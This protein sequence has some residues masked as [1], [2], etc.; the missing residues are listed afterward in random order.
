MEKL[1]RIASILCDLFR[2]LSWGDLVHDARDQ[3]TRDERKFDAVQYRRY[4][5]LFRRS[6]EH[7]SDR[8]GV[9]SGAAR[10]RS[11]A[12]SDAAQLHLRCLLLPNEP[13]SDTGPGVRHQHVLQRA[14]ID[15]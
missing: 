2:T 1:G 5:A 13:R 11:H 9:D 8:P 3:I 10:L 14:G 7:S 6:V 12:P 4:D 15:L